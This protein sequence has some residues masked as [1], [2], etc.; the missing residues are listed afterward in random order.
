MKKA[1]TPATN[2]KRRCVLVLIYYENILLHSFPYFFNTLRT[3]YYDKT[4]LVQ[5]VFFS[6]FPN[7]LCPNQINNSIYY[8]SHHHHYP[9]CK[10]LNFYKKH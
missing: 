9:S 5:C 6:I 2:I 8:H 7:T 3:F 1:K 10:Y 4:L